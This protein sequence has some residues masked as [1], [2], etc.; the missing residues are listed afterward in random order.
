MEKEIKNFVCY[1]KHV[2]LGNCDRDYISVVSL[3]NVII[4]INGWF[5]VEKQQMPCT[6]NIFNSICYVQYRDKMMTICHM[7]SPRTCPNVCL[8]VVNWLNSIIKTLKWITWD[9]YKIISRFKKKWKHRQDWMAVFP[10]HPTQSITCRKWRLFLCL[11]F[12]YF[13]SCRWHQPSQSRLKLPGHN[14]SGLWM[15][16]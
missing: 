15:S 10:L 6:V 16:T 11:T 13:L 14:R 7:S 8:V 4:L 5:H 2:L 12:K 3:C 1:K 9:S